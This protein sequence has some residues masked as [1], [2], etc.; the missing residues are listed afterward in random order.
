MRW[1]LLSLVLLTLAACGNN[2]FRSGWDDTRDA[3]NKPF[4]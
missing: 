2:S 4:K 3:I 1:F